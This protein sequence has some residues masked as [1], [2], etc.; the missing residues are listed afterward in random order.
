MPVEKKCLKFCMGLLHFLHSLF[1]CR[2]PMST[3]KGSSD[4]GISFCVFGNIGF[5][6]WSHSCPPNTVTT[7]L[8]HL[9]RCA[10]WS[11]A[12]HEYNVTVLLSFLPLS[13]K[14]V[15]FLWF[16]LKRIHTKNK[17]LCFFSCW[18]AAMQMALFVFRL[19]S[20]LTE[21]I[22][23]HIEMGSTDRGQGKKE[24]IKKEKKG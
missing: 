11:V 20:L 18:L 10:G 21:R 8:L 3:C 13:P 1:P 22:D 17:W 15:Y 2:Q 16:S 9:H 12:V 24:I 23:N 14:S 5:E 6:L 19:R 4:R 7:A